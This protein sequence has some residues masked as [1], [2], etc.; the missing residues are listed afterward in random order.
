L[1]I[2]HG[3]D[4]TAQNRDGMTPLHQASQHGNEDHAQ[5]LAEHNVV[6]ASQ[7]EHELAPLHQASQRENVDLKQL[8]LFSFLVFIVSFLLY[9][10]L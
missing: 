4:V 2:K 10:Y 3:A 6:E 1:L 8:F 9:L 5:F 7:D